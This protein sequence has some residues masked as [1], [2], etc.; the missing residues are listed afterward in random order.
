MGSDL[1]TQGF[2]ATVQ[3]LLKVLEGRLLDGVHQNAVLG[4][5]LHK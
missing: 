4:F 5:Y 1:P 3:L 2:H